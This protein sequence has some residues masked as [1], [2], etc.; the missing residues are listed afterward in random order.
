[1][2]QD[3]E[4]IRKP[5]NTFKENTRGSLKKKYNP[6]LTV[7]M[8]FWWSW[9]HYFA[10]G[11][12][13]IG[14]NADVKSYRIVRKASISCVLTANYSETYETQTPYGRYKYFVNC[15]SS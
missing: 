5:L 3:T 12:V 9:T 8:I 4:T 14:L 13:W 10:F 6:L 1:M 11:L 15:V 2:N 7:V